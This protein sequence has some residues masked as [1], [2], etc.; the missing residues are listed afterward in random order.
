MKCSETLIRG[1]EEDPLAL[2]GSA[3]FEGQIFSPMNREI[4]VVPVDE[5]TEFKIVRDQHFYRLPAEKG[6]TMPH[7]FHYLAIYRTRPHSSI[8][9]ISK[10][11]RVKIVPGK[12]LEFGRYKSSKDSYRKGG[13]NYERFFWKMECGELVPLSQPIR[14]KSSQ[15]FRNPRITT[16]EK[17]LVA[18]TLEDLKH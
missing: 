13:E 17:L 10:I 7:D 8:T 15:P 12:D 11:K 4:I 3:K 9:H 14:N 16:F 2:Q 5:D 18:R 6:F 1:L